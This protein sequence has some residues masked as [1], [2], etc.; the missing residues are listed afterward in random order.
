MDRDKE[1]EF[2]IG[3]IEKGTKRQLRSLW[4]AYCLHHD[5]EADT[6]DYDY[7]ILRIWRAVE[8]AKMAHEW[9][10]YVNFYMFMSNELV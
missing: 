7:D 5:L 3:Y 9:G 6:R 2:I 4:T 8:K 1:L 10:G